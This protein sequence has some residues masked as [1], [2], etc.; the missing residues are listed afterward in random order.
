MK[1]TAIKKNLFCICLACVFCPSLLFSQKYS[2]KVYS[3]AEG[4]PPFA[5]ERI[6]QDRLG[7]LWFTTGG[8]VV[9]YNGKEFQLFT[10]DEGL[11]DNAT[12]AICEDSY[13]HMWIGTLDGGAVKFSRNGSGNYDLRV[14][15]TNEGL[16]DN[17]V[18]SLKADSAGN[19]WF[20]TKNGVTRI[21]TDSL[22]QSIHIDKYLDGHSIDQVYIASDGTVWL[23]ELTG[24]LSR[25]NDGKIQTL[26]LFQGTSGISGIEEDKERV[27]WVSSFDLGVKRARLK[28]NKTE[29]LTEKYHES[30]PSKIYNL[31][32]NKNGSLLI[33]T[34]GSGLA[35]SDNGKATTVSTKNGLP[36]NNVVNAFEDREGTLWIGTAN[37]GVVKLVSYPFMNYDKESGLA[38]NFV[39]DVIQDRTGS[40]WF[41]SYESGL[42]RFD[43]KEF[44]IFSAKDGL[45]TKEVYALMEDSQGRIWVST[46]GK[47]V[48]VY[49]GKKFI[50][51]N[52]NSI[53]LTDVLCFLEDREK[54]IWFGTDAYGAVRYSPNGTFVQFATAQG[55]AGLRVFSMIQDRKGRIL[56]GCGQPSRFKEAGGL[57]VWDPVRYFKNLNPFTNYT[58]ANGFPTNQVTSVYEDKKGNIWLGTRQAGLILFDDGILKNFT[59]RD[60]LTSNDIVALQE[61][62]KGRLWIGAVKGLNIWNGTNME[63]Y[64]VKQGLISDEVYENAMIA[65]KNGDMWF[66][67]SMGVCQ[68]KVSEK[69][70][71]GIKPLVYVDK[72]RLFGKEISTEVLSAL[73]YSQNSLDFQVVGVELKS[74]KEMSYQF[75]L[76]GFNEDWEAPTSRDFISYTN[77][78]PGRYY[79]KV[80]AKGVSGIWS[81]PAVVTFEIIPAI[82]Q[83]LWFQLGC[84]VFVVILIPMMYRYSLKGWRRFERWRSLRYIAQYKIKEIIGE[85]AM[86]TVYLA[87]DRTNRIHVALKVINEKLM[88]DPDNRSRFERE[89]RILSKL[90]HPFVVKVYATGESMGR[91]YI[92]MEILKNGD[93]KTYLKNNFPLKQND[94]ERLMIGIAEGLGYIHQQAIVHRDFKCENIMLDDHSNP[95]IMDFGLSKSVLVT[96]LTQIGTIM[97]VLSYVAPEQIT[98]TKIDKR[99]DIFSFGVV[100]YVLMTNR[101]PFR[102]E[103]E[104]AMIHSIFNDQPVKPSEINSTVLPLHEKIIMKCLQKNPDDRYQSCEEILDDLRPDEITLY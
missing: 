102:G 63:T 75:M 24:N 101:M 94:L 81:E 32:K 100:M 28:N 67:T 84:M 104:I 20:G 27:I 31:G 78:E 33:S 82:W 89:G 18:L 55:L 13:G 50:P 52:K 53:L 57:S 97:G 12:R 36:E 95:K 58:K 42:T 16:S 2:V 44:K 74:E 41:T 19:V 38:G 86:G 39:L 26:S 69:T 40:F 88:N 77:L 73:P 87:F 21:Q 54:N 7:N 4:F 96:T 14:F 72:I 43:G 34:F 15:R 10:T 1:L 45:P 83:T 98:G 17:A 66:G 48:F 23:G 79:F 91:G 35:L 11:P 103:N 30:I 8:G 22:S 64:T 29:I 6:A 61:D 93:L 47:G 80:R 56:F 68:F 46:V 51:F 85:G 25:I 49:N 59:K 99:S 5:A 9:I 76:Q 60:G 3:T 65:D 62:Q 37:S 92:A 70:T 90:R 71:P